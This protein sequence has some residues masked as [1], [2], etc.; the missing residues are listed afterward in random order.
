[1]Y[2]FAICHMVSSFHNTK[3]YRNESEVLNSYGSFQTFCSLFKHHLNFQAIFL[4]LCT[5]A[6]L[7]Y[8]SWHEYGLD[9]FCLAGESA[10]PPPP[11]GANS[12]EAMRSQLDAPVPPRWYR[13]QLLR[14]QRGNSHRGE[15]Q[16]P[17]AYRHQP[18]RQWPPRAPLGTDTA[19]SSPFAAPPLSHLPSSALPPH[20]ELPFPLPL[21]LFHSLTTAG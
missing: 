15:G 21:S 8:Q 20:T 18:R 17:S 4:M 2:L 16:A 19:R 10:S 11:R 1:M 13:R 3:E 7:R 5:H 14:Q 9:L 12:R 6:P